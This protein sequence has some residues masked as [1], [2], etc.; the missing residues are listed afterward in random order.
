M[1]NIEMTWIKIR[2]DAITKFC[3]L[4][5]S[6]VACLEIFRCWELWVGQCR[7]SFDSVEKVYV[8]ILHFCVVLVKHIMHLK[9]FEICC[10]VLC[11]QVHIQTIGIL[12]AEKTELQ[13]S[14]N[15]SQKSAESRQG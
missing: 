14:L 4:Y 11:V 9:Y 1:C 7:Q 6:E 3:R 2:S 5:R 15:Q 8:C 10:A 12:V 13:S